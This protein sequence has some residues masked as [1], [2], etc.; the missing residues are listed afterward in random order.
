[1]NIFDLF[2]LQP[3]FNLLIG[4]YSAIPGSDFGIAIV[5]FT[6]IVRF[7]MYPL[8][9]KQLHQTQVMRKLQPQLAKIKKQAKGNRQQES[10]QM[11]ELY[12]QN[13]VNPFRSIGILLIQLPIFI[14]LFSVIRIFTQHR[15]QI[16]HF[17]Y[18]FLEGL[19]PIK[20]LIARPDQFNET[21]LG[22]IDLT[23]TA[24]TTNGVDFFLIALAILAAVTQFIMSKQTMPH[25]DSQRRLRDV[26]AEAAEGKQADQAEMNA[27][28]MRKMMKVMPIM[29]FF[30][31]ISLPGAL[32]LYYVTS[33]LIAVLQQGYLLKKDVDEMEALADQP[34]AKKKRATAPAKKAT[35][36]AREKAATEATVTRIVAKTEVKKGK[37]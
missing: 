10:L 18:N 16:E 5:L 21:F 22:F 24:F 36:K 7:A 34:T 4:I 33:N 11:M 32:A 20:E 27:I 9:K 13:G 25:Q 28:V 26:M 17:T 31:M 35:A 37:K 8:L 3:I 15:D 1:M 30:I 23:K 14:A 19:A 29:M 2:I 12:K 6:I